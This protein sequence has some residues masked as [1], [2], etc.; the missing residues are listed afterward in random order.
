MGSNAGRPPEPARPEENP[1][2]PGY[3]ELEKEIKEHCSRRFQSQREQDLTGETIAVVLPWKLLLD[4]S[5]QEPQIITKEIVDHTSFIL[6]KFREFGREIVIE[7]QR[8]RLPQLVRMPKLCQVLH[9]IRQH[10]S[11]DQFL[12]ERNDDG[13]LPFGK[14]SL[15]RI[16]EEE[17]TI[18]GFMEAQMRALV[19]PLPYAD[20]GHIVYAD[21]EVVPLRRGR[22]LGSGGHAE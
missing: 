15:F 7:W 19:R 10:K 1:L 2:P 11:L 13:S 6:S 21:H 3:D 12:A 17:K 18:S 20:R 9:T 5:P 16:F 4:V 8:Y 14:D 22:H